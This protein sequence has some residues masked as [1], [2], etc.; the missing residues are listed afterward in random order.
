MG[1]AFSSKNNPEPAR[2]ATASAAIQ[3]PFAR[4]DTFNGVPP[5]TSRA[6]STF[7]QT[8]DARSGGPSTQMVH[9]I[10]SHRPSDD[11][12]RAAATVRS[13]PAVRPPA[14]YVQTAPKIATH[15][16]GSGY[17]C[18]YCDSNY[19]NEDD[20]DSNDDHEFTLSS[21]TQTVARRG[22]HNVDSLVDAFSHLSLTEE[23]GYTPIYTLSVGHKRVCL[24][25][26]GREK[27]IEA[28]REMLSISNPE[29]GQIYHVSSISRDSIDDLIIPSNVHRKQ[30]T[31]RPSF[32][33]STPELYR[34]LIL[35]ALL[36]GSRVRDFEQ[37]C[38]K[39]VQLGE[40]IL[41]MPSQNNRRLKGKQLKLRTIS[42]QVFEVK[43]KFVN[44]NDADKRWMV[45]CETPTEPLPRKVRQ[46]ALLEIMGGWDAEPRVT[47]ALMRYYAGTRFDFSN[48]KKANNQK[49][50]KKPEYKPAE[51]GNW[52]LLS[53]IYGDAAKKVYPAVDP[54]S[55]LIQLAKNAGHVQLNPEQAEAVA[56]Y[57]CTTCPGFVVES[58]PGS[59]KTM[60]AAAMA[61][62]YK[63]E[64]VQLFLSTAN[65][66][67]INMAL[68]LAKLDYGFLKAIHLIS[69]EREDLMTAETRSPFSVLSL[70][71]ENEKLK[72]A[73]E[74]LEREME[75]APNDEEK[76]KIKG[77]ID[78]ACGPIFNDSY[79]IYF[80]TVD[81]ILGRLYKPNQGGKHHVDNIKKQLVN[82][83]K[84]IVVDE[85]SQLTESALNALILC[86]PNAQIVL[87][88]DSKQLPPF[89]Y[90]PKEVV[91]ELAARPALDVFKDKINLPVIK[92]SRVYRAS[93]SMMKHYSD[94]FYKGEL[95]SFKAESAMNP[96]S[97]FGARSG[98]S[99]RLF[100]KVDKGIA[101]KQ[102][103][104]KY[105]FGELKR[106]R[107]IVNMLKN[108]GYK[109]KDVMIISYYEAQRKKAEDELKELGD[110]ELLT[111]DSAQGREKK[112]VI[113]L[114]TR[115]SVPSDAGAF[116][117]CALRC[118]VAVSR[119][120]EALIV[121]GHPSI[122]SAP[123]WARVL[124]Q[125]YFKHVEDSKGWKGAR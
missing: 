17:C 5:A 94:C 51:I 60:T 90:T 2:P 83:V 20:D 54:S 37:R 108:S 11:T 14:S 91:S 6:P 28:K 82:T 104:S 100:W 38:A 15:R 67:V 52:E 117:K 12:R 48:S 21:H 70:A 25:E 98:G 77:A 41:D 61:V 57:K 46:G 102:G 19:D 33:Y 85:A 86:F 26:P 47:G 32:V 109:E 84:R 22:H 3:T 99:K 59:G 43:V 87:I 97:C 120:Q 1:G 65:V 13:T 123:N 119:H 66:P 111:V 53:C 80:A 24:F 49:N 71:K 42:G 78:K 10:T 79:D 4:T 29:E 88:G 118:N 95:R 103:T 121:L 44:S 81:M 40:L 68:A 116:F 75:H 93:P 72:V 50:Q 92:L 18:D 76:A 30:L 73:I 115:T 36:L 74:A 107:Y 89:R 34:Q 122:A 105:N 39:V 58:P 62:S 55:P 7:S 112:V 8:F 27:F 45:E 16:Y 23:T 63:G 64:G 113:V 96:F 125:K 31:D 56:R 69:S 35:P 106:L 101:K 114:T 9:L 124:D 110:Y